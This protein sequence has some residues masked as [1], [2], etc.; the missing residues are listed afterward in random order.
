MSA[1]IFDGK[2][3]AE[4]LLVNVRDRVIAL[5]FVPKLVS[6]YKPD[7]LGSK[8]YTRIKAEKA[9]SVGIEFNGVEIFRVEEAVE[10]IREIWEEGKVKGVLVQHPTGE[11]AFS[12]NHWEMLVN[13]IPREKDVDGLRENSPFLPATVRAIMVALSF[14]KI[15]LKDCK[16]AVVGA[17]GMV[18]KPL[19][20]A[21]WERGAKVKEID[22]TTDEVWFQTKNADVVIS[23]V[24]KHN[25]IVGDQIKTG[26]VVIDV[27]SPGGDVDFES[28]RAV[29]SFLTPVPGGI[30]PL[31]V[32][33]LLENVVIA[34]E[35]LL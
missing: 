4:D 16:V 32:A 28:A 2:A 25:L 20:R 15:T 6:F 23:C 21:L 13:A 11:F 14:A 3:V 26:A 8:L 33:C 29:A 1:K 12:P 18:G 17:S 34:A 35:K 30:G 24:G 19:V 10:K 5:G 27:G 31:T 7:D 22:E 9:K